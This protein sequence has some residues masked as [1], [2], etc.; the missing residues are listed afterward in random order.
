[1]IFMN[2][3]TREQHLLGQSSIYITGDE[4]S[5]SP[6]ALFWLLK[7]LSLKPW[8]HYEVKPLVV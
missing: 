8:C 4:I 3:S 7:I 2:V 5:F 1:M 6:L